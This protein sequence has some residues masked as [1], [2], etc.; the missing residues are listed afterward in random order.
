MFWGVFGVVWGVL[1][2][3]GV[4]RWT[5]QNAYV[6]VNVAV[7]IIENSTDEHC[8]SLGITLSKITKIR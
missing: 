6:A 1:G 7:A 8:Y 4:I 5:A 2:W 3:F